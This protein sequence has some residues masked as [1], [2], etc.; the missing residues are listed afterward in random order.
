MR[1]D[2]LLAPIALAQAILGARALGRMARGAGARPIAPTTEP[3]PHGERIAAI[4]P[5]L[6]ERGRLGGC[7]EGLIAHGPEIGEI[8]VVDGGSEDGTQDLVVAFQARD[9]R[10][11]LIDASPVPPGWNGKA[12]G[13]QI[14][15][16]RI[17]AEC[18]W[19]LT[20]DADVRPAA[21]LARSL[22]VHAA[23]N[24]LAAL[25]VAS[26]QELSGPGEALVHPAMLA[27]LVYR[28]GIP[29]R[30]FERVGEVQA[31]GQCFLLR[32]DPI[33]RCGGFGAARDSLCE[34]VTIA[35]RL[36]AMG[37]RVGFYEAGTLVSVRM[38]AGWRDAWDNWPRSL[39]MRDRY[40]G[41]GALFGLLEVTLAQV[42][43]LPLLAAL[44]LA[45]RGR[46]WAIGVNAALV[47][48]RMGVLIGTARAYR[49]RPW[50][51]WLSPLC[52]L[53]VALRLWSSA[54]RR[55]HVWRGRIIMRRSS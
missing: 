24:G 5:V 41:L 13:L 42:L 31:N 8:L 39:P 21:L 47:A 45:G 52:D 35:R 15:L 3:P 19:V 6:N 23:A 26:L 9:S 40:S 32:R 4:V 25:S 53:P 44:A 12:W 22:L 29:G 43:P 46:C 28:F 30:A 10:V 37:Y 33:E 11:R 20:I 27:T 1:F 51:Y 49:A 2:R 34:D 36:V 14:G 55:R 50:S 18:T 17:G 16:E 38:Y 54:L 7:L 48:A